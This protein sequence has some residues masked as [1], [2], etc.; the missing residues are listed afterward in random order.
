MKKYIILVGISGSGK[1]TFCASQPDMAVINRDTLREIYAIDV[2]RP[3]HHTWWYTDSGLSV[4]EREIT[5]QEQVIRMRYIRQG[6]SIIDDNTNLD[7]RFIE[8]KIKEA[9]A[10]GYMV[11]IG[12]LTASNDLSLCIER[13]K[14]RSRMVGQVVI[15]KQHAKFTS[16]IKEMN[17][18]GIKYQYV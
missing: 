10:A 13:D 3:N 7:W 5:A 15:K 2:K 8:P 18:R 12:V 11:I 14:M 1:S 4:R 6:V 17:R 16:L 9:K